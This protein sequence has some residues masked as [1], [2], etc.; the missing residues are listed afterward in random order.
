M[1]LVGFEAAR[2]DAIR[3]RQG[4]RHLRFE[5]RYE[6]E[7]GGNPARAL[8][9]ARQSWAEQKEP[10]DARNVLEAALA[11]GDGA[12]ASQVTEFIVQTRIEDARLRELVSRS[13]AR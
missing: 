10:R 12:A 1:D 5:S 3:L 13:S 6:L 2:F 11:A 9:L 4:T 7:L 8:E